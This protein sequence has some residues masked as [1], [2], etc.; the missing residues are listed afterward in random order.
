[1]SKKRLISENNIVFVM[2]D[3]ESKGDS[4]DRDRLLQLQIGKLTE[5]IKRLEKGE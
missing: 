2:N 3:M 5:R 1:M 4:E